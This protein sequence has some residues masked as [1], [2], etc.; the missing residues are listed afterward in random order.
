MTNLKKK[1]I[2]SLPL[3]W[4][5]LPLF[6][7]LENQGFEPDEAIENNDHQLP[8]KESGKQA[9]SMLQIFSFQSDPKCIFS[10]NHCPA[11]M[12]KV[13]SSDLKNI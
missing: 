2:P 5:I 12:L 7:T 3:Q 9:L 4:S 1:K 8:E 13:Q 6:F 11:L 10:T